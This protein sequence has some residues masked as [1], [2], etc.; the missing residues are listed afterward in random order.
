MQSLLTT[1][2]T[3]LIENPRLG[4]V[5]FGKSN[6]FKKNRHKY[7][8]IAFSEDMFLFVEKTLSL[9]AQAK[10]PKTS[11][12]QKL[13][14]PRLGSIVLRKCPKTKNIGQ[15]SLPP[16]GTIFSKTK[17]KIFRENFFL[18]REKISQCI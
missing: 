8:K 2:S 7:Y 10:L 12:I 15:K 13:I 11:S 16:I 17:K 18:T 14:K 9:N 1:F 6:Q 4:I 3:H 5:V